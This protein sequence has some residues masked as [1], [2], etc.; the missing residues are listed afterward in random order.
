L[1]QQGP[2]EV[3]IPLFSKVFRKTEKKENHKESKSTVST[4][5]MHPFVISPVNDIFVASFAK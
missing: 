4:D 3:W 5:S 2:V 1:E